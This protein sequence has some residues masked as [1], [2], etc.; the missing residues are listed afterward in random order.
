MANIIGL[1]ELRQHVDF[2]AE[3]VKKGKTF[4]VVRRSKPLFK[5]TPPEESE[6]WESVIDFTKMKKGGFLIK[7]LL[8]RV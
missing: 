1:K 4:V 2:Y 7:D 5:I 6:I 8:T 3:A